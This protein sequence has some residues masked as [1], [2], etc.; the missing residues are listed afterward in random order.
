MGEGGREMET[1]RQTAR[2]RGYICVREREGC[3]FESD[4]SENHSDKECSSE[5]R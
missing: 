1:D 5:S 2:E 4:Q 3:V